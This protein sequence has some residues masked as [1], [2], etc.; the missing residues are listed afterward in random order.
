METTNQVRQQVTTLSALIPLVRRLATRFRRDYWSPADREDILQEGFVGL[1]E[2]VGRFDPDRGCALSTYAGKRASG[3]MFDHVRDICRRSRERLTEDDPQDQ[4]QYRKDHDN[5]PNRSIESGVMLMR[6]SRFLGSDLDGLDFLDHDEREIIRLRFF[7][8]MTCREV[9]EALGISAATVCRTE[10]TA[11]TRLRKNF[12]LKHCGPAAT[13]DGAIGG[14]R[15]E[16]DAEA[17]TLDE[18]ADQ[19]TSKDASLDDVLA[20]LTL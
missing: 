12:V 14:S 15:A 8:G 2:A 16:M 4:I 20:S 13:I 9:A 6:F 10:R 7:E 18:T 3:A 19:G 5:G 11:L 1:M 17:D